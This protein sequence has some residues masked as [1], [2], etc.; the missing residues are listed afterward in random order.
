MARGARAR[1]VW[2]LWFVL[3]GALFSI[4]TGASGRV[5]INTGSLDMATGS[6]SLTLGGD[7][8]F[9]FASKVS[10]HH[11]VFAPRNCNFSPRECVPGATLDLHARWVG[12]DAPGTA[13]LEGVT[14]SHLGGG[15]SPNAMTVDFAG[16]VVLP[17]LSPRV[18]VSA[19]FSFT[20][21]FIHSG[22]G[23]TTVQEMLS[24][25][26]TATATLTT[27]AAFPNNWHVDRVVYTFDQLAV[28]SGW[29]AADVGDV[30]SSGSSSFNPSTRAFTIAGAG[31]DIWGTADAFRF[32]YR[33]IAG[34][35]EIVVK[36]VSEQDTHTFAKAGV[37]L[38]GPL[39][40][41]RGARSSTCGPAAASSS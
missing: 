12:N 21:L 36:V 37:M 18:T 22:P 7:R 14:Y 6:G 31:G 33:P 34:N 32:A 35:G 9:T 24:G 3:F 4:G 10:E 19:G 29:Q 20:G 11:G 15:T 25:S 1:S 27:L 40:G 41:R 28:P 2:L 16:S 30:G 38:R 13:T 5:R 23:A 8:G 17:P 39:D 26:G